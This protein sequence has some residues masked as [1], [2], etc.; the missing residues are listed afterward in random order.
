MKSMKKAIGILLCVAMLFGFAACGQP[1][2][3]DTSSATSNGTET[4]SASPS[5]ED[6]ITLTF[7]LWGDP[8]EQETTQKVLDVYNG[9]QDKSICESA[10]DRA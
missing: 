1:A 9:L 7:S 5:Q 6:K 10:A 4:A 8:A 3:T 2:A